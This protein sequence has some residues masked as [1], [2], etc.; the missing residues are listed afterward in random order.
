MIFFTFWPFEPNF[1]IKTCIFISRRDL[2]ATVKSV[3]TNEDVCSILTVI[4]Y[5]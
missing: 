3:K 2:A 4:S 5:Y 1:L